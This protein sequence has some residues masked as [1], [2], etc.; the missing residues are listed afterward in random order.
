[1]AAPRVWSGVFGAWVAATG[2]TTAVAPASPEVADTAGDATAAA[3]TGA[4]VDSKPAVDTATS[5]AAKQPPTD[6]APAAPDADAAVAD[7]NPCKVKPTLASLEKEYFAASCAFGSCHSAAKHAGELV[8][9]EGKSYAQLIGV[10][11]LHPGASGFVRVEPGKP[12]DSF[13]YLKVTHPQPGQGKL[14]PVGASEP[15]DADGGI[16]ALKAW[17]A[18]GAPK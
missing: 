10:Q 18:A 3:D 8:L 11:A 14:M 7:V 1:M 12:D 2:C 6:T 17:I 16:A 13:L 4:A 5:D 9:E 15:V